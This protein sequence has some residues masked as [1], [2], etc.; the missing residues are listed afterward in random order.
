METI[1]Y[2]IFGFCMIGVGWTSYSIGFK[3]G[4]KILVV[5]NK[6]VSDHYG[7]CVIRSLI[8]NKYNPKLLVLKA[9]EEQ[10]NL[11]VE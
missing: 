11:M 6:E 10:K 5:S 7:A 2:M 9:G 8:E 1:D 4:L 3:E